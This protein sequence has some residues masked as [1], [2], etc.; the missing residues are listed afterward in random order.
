MSTRLNLAFLVALVSTIVVPSQAQSSRPMVVD[1]LFSLQT[2]GDVRMSA[3][4]SSIAVVIQRAWSNPETFRPYTMFGKDHADIWILPADGGPAKNITRGAKDGTGYWNP[5]WSPDGQRLALLSTKGGDNVRVYV[6]GKGSDRLQRMSERGVDLRAGASAN[7]DGSPNPIQ[8]LDERRLLVTVLPENEQPLAFRQRRQTQRIASEAWKKAAQGGEPTSSVLESGVA[9][10]PT[11]SAQL[12]LIEVPTARAR[13]LA[14]GGIRHALLS[15]DREHIAI[16]TQDRAPAP[17]AGRPLPSSS[18]RLGMI[19]L[20]DGSTVRWIDGMFNPTVGFG[21]SPHRWSPRASML[22]V[23]ASETREPS[24]M[25][26]VFV[27][28]T[29]A[30]TAR[31][32]AASLMAS[33]LAWS[34][35]EQLLALARVPR[36]EQRLDWWSLPVA[37]TEKNARKLTDGLA[38]VPAELVRIARSNEMIGI[39]DGKLWSFD[40][41]NGRHRPLTEAL[42]PRV[43][44]FV[45]PRDDERIA[46]PAASVIVRLREGDSS[47][48]ARIDLSTPGAEILSLP[49]PPESTAL[50]EY[51]PG[52]NLAVFTA[53]Q[54][55]YGSFLWTARGGSHD[56]TRRIVLNEQVAGIA[57]A[58]RM[59]IEYRSADG[60]DLKGLVLLPVGYERG[61]RYP[62]VTW[63]YP[64]T[65]VRNTNMFFWVTKNQAHI[66]NLNI[67]AGHGYAVLIPSMPNKSRPRDPYRELASG[68]LPAVDRVIGLGIADPDRVGVIG[69]SAGGFATYGLITQTT[70]FKTAIAIAGYANFTSNYGT[71]SGEDRYTDF[72]EKLMQVRFSEGDVFGLDTPPW[73]DSDRYLRNSPITFIDRVETPLLIL[74]GDIDYVPMQ[75]A[76][77]V[78]TSLYRLGRRVRFV[79]YWGES[80]VVTDSPANIRD[81]WQEILRWF[82]TYLRDAR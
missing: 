30:A 24:A 69:Q 62:L 39:A 37:L 67:L 10:H 64:G 80:H 45:W 7:A 22:A 19:A 40:L 16:I 57:E 42:G 1:D 53:P 31:K 15:P 63:V 28:S 4:G 60:E 32:V 20:R 44:A 14:E 71:F 70:R 81:R 66:D 78:F 82:D 51:H 55:P 2:L 23:L 77:E 9:V 8:W 33:A 50:V 47:S 54:H 27:V 12:L 17:E 61:K 25:K 34:E 5:V 74:H 72:D 21:T 65:I 38:A 52:R 73:V 6:W 29:G 76:E 46:A 11:G 49:Q 43:S 56:F 18:S 59:L 41:T 75:Q 58:E 36:G 48:L 13:V 26:T 3:D 79:R 68:V 35:D